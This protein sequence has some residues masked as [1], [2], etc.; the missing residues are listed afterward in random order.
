M[1]VQPALP[2]RLPPAHPPALP[3]HVS[4]IP[5]SQLLPCSPS[6]AAPARR[7]GVSPVPA[8]FRLSV[9]PSHSSLAVPSPQAG[10]GRC[11]S[12]SSLFALSR[13]LF[14]SL[15]MTSASTRG[16]TAPP[17]PAGPAATCLC[18]GFNLILLPQ[19]PRA[20]R[21]SL[22]PSHQDVCAW[23]CFCPH[24]P[25][26]PR[27]VPLG[28]CLACQ[29]V[30]R[31]MRCGFAGAVPPTCHLP[32]CVCVPLVCW[33]VTVSR[34]GGCIVRCLSVCASPLLSGLSRATQG[35]PHRCHHLSP[36]V[37]CAWWQR[38]PGTCPSVSVR[39][40][41][42]WHC[43]HQCGCSQALA[44]TTGMYGDSQ[45][46]G[47]LDGRR[48]GG[49]STRPPKPRRSTKHWWVSSVLGQEGAVLVGTG[50][51]QG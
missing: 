48:K 18:A 20:L 30:S 34:R 12:S 36:V 4:S 15:S 45:G 19:L 49:V 51:P 32:W 38:G 26:V 9:C 8:T 39:L 17:H 2:P 27:H 43:G 5:V 16:S 11:C 22:V 35:C 28:V 7:F 14:F 31:G 10:A 25:Q 46:T 24:R 6:P 44:V 21:S 37:P 40:S 50:S 33:F 13:S 3:R 1:G 29:W 41:P 42:P 47:G 23:V